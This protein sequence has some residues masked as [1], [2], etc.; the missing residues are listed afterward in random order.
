MKQVLK[1]AVFA[2]LTGVL[3]ILSCK[4]EYSCENCIGGNQPPIANAG[5][6][7]TILLPINNVTLDGSA[8]RDRD[9]YI[10]GYQWTKISGPSSFNIVN[11]N[12]VQTQVT[13]LVQGIYQFELK[14]TDAGGLSAKDTMQVIANAIPSACAQLVPFGTLSIPREYVCTATAGNKILFAGGAIQITPTYIASSRVDIYDMVTQTWSTA[15]LSMPR[16]A[17]VSATLGNKIFFTDGYYSASSRVDIYDA[18][19]NLWSTTELGTARAGLIS[20]AAG[21][22]VV[23]AGGYGIPDNDKIDVYNVTSGLWSTAFLAQPRA[24]I[25]A[26]SFGNKIYFSGGQD[27]QGNQGVGFSD[28]VDIYDASTDSWSTITMSEPRW[29][30]TTIVADNKIFWAG[31][32]S[33][34]DTNGDAISNPSVEM[35][36]I[37]NGN[38]LHHQLSQTPIMSS[39]IMNNKIIFLPAFAGSSFSIDIYDISTQTWSACNISSPEWTHIGWHKATVAAGNN[40]YI[41]GNIQGTTIPSRIWKLRF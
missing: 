39:G 7:Q 12:A 28:K 2:L 15:E 38:R 22:K 33:S 27:L 11:A 37:N 13:N 23:F 18:S 21:N 5:P 17:L 20:A 35:Y 1:F 31:G 40:M 3:I 14:V 25:S 19:A 29:F 16:S 41:I 26:T 10:T 32:C 34:F 9:G 6:D 36:D 30:H 4:K 8:S 24:D